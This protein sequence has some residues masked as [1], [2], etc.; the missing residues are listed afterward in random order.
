MFIF[1]GA[2]RRSCEK[3]LCPLKHGLLAT[4][5]EQVGALDTRVSCMTALQFYRLEGPLPWEVQLKAC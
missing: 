3:I 4:E 1:P 2:S 5:T